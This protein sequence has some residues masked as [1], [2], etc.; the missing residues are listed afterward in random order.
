MQY[1]IVTTEQG[2]KVRIPLHALEMWEPTTRGGSLIRFAGQ[3]L[4]VRETP[5]AIDAQIAS[6][7]TLGHEEP[8]P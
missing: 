3:T 5:D 6:L 1:L 7:R 2:Q 8:V 4:Y